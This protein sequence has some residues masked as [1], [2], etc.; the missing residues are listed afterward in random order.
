MQTSYFRR[1]K[2]RRLLKRLISCDISMKGLHW[3]FWKTDESFNSLYQA[4]ASLKVSVIVL[5]VPSPLNHCSQKVR[6]LACRLHS[7]T[8]PWDCNGIASNIKT[9]CFRR[10]SNRSC[11]GGYFPQLENIMTFFVEKRADFFCAFSCRIMTL[12]VFTAYISVWHFPL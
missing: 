10:V 6:G 5:F 7:L 8:M 3:R 9:A 1:L 4:S 2:Q 12:F 11:Q